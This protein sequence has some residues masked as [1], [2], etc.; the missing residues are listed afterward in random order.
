MTT[1]MITAMTL[2]ALEALALGIFTLRTAIS[3]KTPALATTLTTI[4]R[5]TSIGSQ[6]LRSSSGAR[7]QRVRTS[8]YGMRYL[9]LDQPCRMLSQLRQSLNHIDQ[10]DFARRSLFGRLP[11]RCRQRQ[12]GLCADDTL[13]SDSGVLRRPAAT[14][15]AWHSYLRE[16][17]GGVQRSR[18]GTARAD[19]RQDPGP[20][21]VGGEKVPY[22]VYIQ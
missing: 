1:V 22:S 14:R 18:Q 5:A 10:L 9:N 19:G 21:C 11:S 8:A 6:T 12:A 20:V 16:E 2:A 13:A 3:R 17:N 4:S 15:H 7:R